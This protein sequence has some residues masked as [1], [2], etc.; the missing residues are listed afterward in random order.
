MQEAAG[1]GGA[2]A[3]VAHLE[4]ELGIGRHLGAEDLGGQAGLLLGL[5]FRPI[6]GGLD[7]AI[8]ERR[9][10]GAAALEA[11]C[12]VATALAVVRLA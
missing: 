10:V 1:A 11:A 5:G 9:N 8:G 3:G 4:R 7:T 6:K 12:Y 2:D